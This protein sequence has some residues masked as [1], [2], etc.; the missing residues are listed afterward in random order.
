MRIFLVRHG[1]SESNVE[2][3][4]NRKKA[5]HAISL[6]EEGRVQARAAGK[7]LAQYFDENLVKKPKKVT[8]YSRG[9]TFLR[10]RLW[11]SPYLRTRQTAEEIEKTCI[12]PQKTLIPMVN[13]RDPGWYARKQGDSYFLDK[14]EHTLLAEQQFGLFDGLSDAERKK[15]YPDM[16]AY[17]AK[18]KAFEGKFWPKMPLGESRFEVAQR[19]HQSFG[20]FHRDT[21]KHGIKNIVVVGHGTTNRAFL[22][23]WLHLPYEWMHE[24]PNPKNC[25]IR[26][27]DGNVDKGYIFEGFSGGQH[28]GQ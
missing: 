4:V 14:K 8:A 20:T 21:E 17:Y 1:E 26:L 6:T 13:T 25:S 23:M 28:K 15:L 18:C 7:F 5:D 9:P 12:L 2:W 19:V 16:Q 24:E 3:E 22:M 27:V 11:H 10:T